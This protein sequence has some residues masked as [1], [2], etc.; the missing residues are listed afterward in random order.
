M[1]GGKTSYSLYLLNT[2]KT[3]TQPTFTTVTLLTYVATGSQLQVAKQ[4]ITSEQSN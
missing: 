2:N 1:Q 4:L 3:L